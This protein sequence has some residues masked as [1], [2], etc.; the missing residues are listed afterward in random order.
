MQELVEK[1]N[2]LA[3]K[4][5][6]AHLVFEEAGPELD[7]KKVKCLGA[8]L[9]TASKVE[10]VKQNEKELKDLHEEVLTL[11]QIEQAAKDSKA[12][13]KFLSGATK[14]TTHPGEQKD[15]ARRTEFKTIGTELTGSNEFKDW[16]ASGEHRAGGVKSFHIDAYPSEL[17][18]PQTKTLFETTAGWAPES[19]RLTDFTAAVT[20]PIQVIDVVPSSPTSF[21][22]IKY[23]EETTRTHAAA[24]KAEGVAFPEAT[25]AFT[26]QSQAV[27]KVS[28][29]IPVTDEQLEDIPQVEGYLTERLTFGLRQRAD[30][31][32]VT[33]DGV[34]PNL[35][36][37]LNKGGIQTQALGA[38]P[39]LDAFYKAIDLVRVTGRAEP[40]HIVIHPTNWQPIRLLRTADGIYIYG[41]PMDAGVLRMWGLPVIV[42]DVITLG[43][44]LVA[45][46]TPIHCSIFEKKGI[47]IQ[48]GYI[49]AQFTEGK[50]TIR[51]D[52]RMAFVWRRA[53]EFCTVT[54]I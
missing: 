12:R 38:D 30:T 33:G 42:G 53:T 10:K 50:R 6:I 17:K 43:T 23:M 21:E 31:Q 28:T 16:I 27:E 26:E 18:V 45:S 4:Q 8:N 40:T 1:R 36:G 47:D 20:R 22:L 49:N 19:I 37:V 3:E 41:S 11:V 35:L 25:F 29:S 39:V 2:E 32:V 13:D 7:F 34:A 24:E 14:A 5:K 46:F 52:T 54:G 48:I 51:A 9:T 44:G 15:G